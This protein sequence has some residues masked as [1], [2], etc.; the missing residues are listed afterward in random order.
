MKVQQIMER[1]GIAQTGRAIAYIK[2]GLEEM[3][4]ISNENIVKGTVASTTGTGI[5]FVELNEELSDSVIQF[6]GANAGSFATSVPVGS[7]AY[8]SEA[9]T[10]PHF[11]KTTASSGG[12]TGYWL[13]IKTKANLYNLKT[14]GVYFEVTGLSIGASY[15]FTYTADGGNFDQAGFI[16]V[17]VIGSAAPSGTPVA[18]NADYGTGS[19]AGTFD[20]VTN[21]IVFTPTA[22]NIFIT[23]YSS[24]VDGS[25]DITDKYWDIGNISLKPTNNVIVD[26]NGGFGNFKSGMKILV[27]DSASNDTDESDNTSVG[28]YTCTAVGTTGSNTVITVS[29]TLNDESAEENLTVRGQTIN[30]M[31]IIKDKRYYSIPS[32]MVKLMDVRIKNH[33]NT[34]DQY[35]SIPRM[36]GRPLN[37]DV[38]EI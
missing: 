22:T 15:T 14:C 23:F 24:S 21:T 27:N 34:K 37:T 38:D 11:F 26:T 28:Y 5:S 32:D 30:Y 25:N 4:L 17:V 9:M 33:L 2:D 1:A 31:D 29:D 36:I 20:D 19:H 10:D 3:N 16:G 7:T 8:E 12:T 13:R 35:R 18:P 6:T